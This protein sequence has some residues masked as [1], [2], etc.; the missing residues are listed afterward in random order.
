MLLLNLLNI[1]TDLLD[2]CLEKDTRFTTN[3]ERGFLEEEY[4][5]NLSEMLK[6][7]IFDNNRSRGAE[8]SETE[9]DDDNDNENE[10]E[11]ENE[12]KNDSSAH[13]KLDEQFSIKKV[14]KNILNTGS[15]NAKEVKSMQSRKNANIVGDGKSSW[16]DIYGRERDAEGNIV[17]NIGRYIPPAARPTACDANAHNEKIRSLRRQLKGCLNRITEQN[18]HYITN[19][20]RVF[21]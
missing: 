18:M 6:G 2:F 21:D 7:N 14:S 15:S 11:N 19:Q 4:D 16:E 10:N 20:V 3:N 13:L 5:G 1:F 9:D 17:Q 12:S 8:R